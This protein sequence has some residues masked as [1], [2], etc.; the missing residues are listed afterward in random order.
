MDKRITIK[1]DI[2]SKFGLKIQ[3]FIEWKFTEI[4]K[5]WC[6]KWSGLAAQTNLPFLFDFL[7]TS[8]C[9]SVSWRDEKGWVWVRRKTIWKRERLVEKLSNNSDEGERLKM[10]KI[11]ILFLVYWSKRSKTQILSGRKRGWE[12]EIEKIEAKVYKVPV[13]NSNDPLK[14][15]F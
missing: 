2:V 7:C 3:V 4:S 8:C 13:N 12:G 5:Y 9:R 1:M 14:R 11:T 10:K 15:N 6:E